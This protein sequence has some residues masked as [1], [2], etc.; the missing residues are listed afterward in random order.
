MNRENLVIS[1]K[2]FDTGYNF[3]KKGEV[4]RCIPNEDG[5]MVMAETIEKDAFEENFTFFLDVVKEEWEMLGLTINGKAIS[6]TAFKKKANEGHHKYG[7][8]LHI[9][10]FYTHPKKLLY[11]FYPSFNG[12][13]ADALNDAYINYVN[14]VDGHTDGLDYQ[15]GCT[16]L[17][18]RGNSGI[19]IS[20]EDIRWKQENADANF[21]F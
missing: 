19:P 12:N 16:P 9:F 6:K 14:V 3:F 2:D 11:G 10:F 7:K 13:K 20:F 21:V 4:Y 5:F 18:Q 17:V 8:S 1:N 15:H